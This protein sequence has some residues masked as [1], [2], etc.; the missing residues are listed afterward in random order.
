MGEKSAALEVFHPDRIAS[1]ILGMGDM[2]SLIEEAERKVDRGK[3][4]QLA[5]KLKK[6]KGFD[7]Q[8]FRDQLQQMRSMGG[9]AGL[10]DKLPGMSALP[11]AARNQV[12]DRQFIRMEAMINSM[13]AQERRFPDILRVRANAA[14]P[15]GPA[16]RSGPQ[17]HAQAVPADAENDEADVQGRHAEDAAWAEGSVALLGGLPIWL[18]RLGKFRGRQ[19]L[20]GWPGHLSARC[21][22]RFTFGKIQVE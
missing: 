16:C 13:T 2:L 22:T 1:R 19:A 18:N 10:L 4:E 5:Q 12:D 9:V 15:P 17:P 3:A 7:L 21:K 11:Q 8:D 14:S 20:A 6:G